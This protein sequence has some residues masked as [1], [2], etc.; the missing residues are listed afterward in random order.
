M[1]DKEKEQGGFLEL[2]KAD[3]A[4]SIQY[5]L[6]ELLMVK[7]RKAAKH[8]GISQVAIAGGVSANSALRNALETHAKKYGWQVFVPAFA[9]CTDNAAMIAMAAHFKYQKGMF[10]GMDAAPD[11]RM[12][13]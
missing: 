5:T 10:L 12:Q 13:F 9:Y 1:R 11:P 6:V 3:I 7:V 2:H 4:A 8:F